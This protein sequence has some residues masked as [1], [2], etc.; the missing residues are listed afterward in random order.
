MTT[1]TGDVTDF[2]AE[3]RNITTA[4][5]ERIQQQMIQQQTDIATLQSHL[6]QLDINSLLLTQ[7]LITDEKIKSAL[8]IV[9]FSASGGA[10]DHTPNNWQKPIL[11]SNAITD[12]SQITESK[13][14]RDWNRN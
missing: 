4:Y 8:N 1:I 3:Q 6:A 9:E 12:L 10:K 5:A 2:K 14:Y 7:G 11:E 13:T